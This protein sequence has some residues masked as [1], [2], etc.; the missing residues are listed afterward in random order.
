MDAVM[1]PDNSQSIE[2]AVAFLRDLLPT[3][4]Q[5]PK[6]GIVC[7]SGLGGLGRVLKTADKIEIPYG[8]VPHFPQST[9]V[10]DSC[11]PSKTADVRI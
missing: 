4:L 1:G 11:Q 9:G 6:V 5:A 2:S 8:D 10:F 7:G 3:A